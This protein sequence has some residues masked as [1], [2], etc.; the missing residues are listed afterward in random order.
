MH[1]LYASVGVTAREKFGNH[2]LIT[3]IAEEQLIRQRKLY[4][5]ESRKIM[6][7]TYSLYNLKVK[8]SLGM[9]HEI[10]QSKYQYNIASIRHIR[11]KY[12]VMLQIFMA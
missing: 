9:V 12:C 2:Y 8:I 5:F 1:L 10:I 3:Y 6:N 4:H 11:Y 7:K